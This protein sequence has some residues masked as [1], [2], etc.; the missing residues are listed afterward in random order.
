[1]IVAG[2]TLNSSALVTLAV[3]V[4]VLIAAMVLLLRARRRRAEQLARLKD[5]QYRAYLQRSVLG[6]GWEASAATS[7][8]EWV[9]E[10][11]RHRAF[12][13]GLTHWKIYRVNRLA[14]ARRDA[15]SVES[16]WFHAAMHFI[17]R[18]I[19]APWFDHLLEDREHM[20]AE[21]RSRRFIAAATA[22]Q[23]LS[24]VVHLVWGRIWDALTPFKPRSD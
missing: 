11:S 18:H 17:P 16:G 21:G 24:L 2:V 14:A 5:Y 23:C 1:M 10:M 15:R 12:G 6:S 13:L 8:L 19:R 22:V 4:V 7:Y 3:A 9:G 20:A